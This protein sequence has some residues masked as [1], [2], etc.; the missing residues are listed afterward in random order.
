MG[1]DTLTEEILVGMAC[2]SSVR[3]FCPGE[4][5]FLVIFTDLENLR[6]RFRMGP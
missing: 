4:L 6:L 1:S 2:N 3:K 5:L